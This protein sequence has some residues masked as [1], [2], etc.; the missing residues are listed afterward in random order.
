MTLARGD[1]KLA[2]KSF[3]LPHQ[4]AVLEIKRQPAWPQAVVPAACRRVH[5]GPSPPAAPRGGRACGMHTQVRTVSQGRGPEPDVVVG[6]TPL[7]CAAQRGDLGIVQALLQVAPRPST[8]C[9]RLAPSD[10]ATA[11]SDSDCSAGMER[12]QSIT[13]AAD[14]QSSSQ[15]PALPM[16]DR[17]C[18]MAV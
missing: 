1:D 10:V 12:L 14:R 18:C 17:S 15:Q 6:S 9:P 11:A 2:Y 13:G 16:E 5:V 8:C 4:G 3:G 7:H